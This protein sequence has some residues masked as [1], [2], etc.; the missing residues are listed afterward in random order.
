MLT[1]TQELHIFMKPDCTKYSKVK[2]CELCKL[3]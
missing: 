1:K 3:Y 2:K